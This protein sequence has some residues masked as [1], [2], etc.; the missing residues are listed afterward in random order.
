MDAKKGSVTI[1]QAAGR[2]GEG[3]E[4]QTYA[5]APKAEIAI[6]DGRGRRFSIKE[7]T[8]PDIAEGAI[9]TCALS[10]DKKQIQ[11]LVAEGP[12]FQGVIKGVDAA[13]KSVTIATPPGRGGDAEEKTLFVSVEATVVVDDGK[14]RR[15]SVKEAKLTDLPIGAHASV[16]MAP[17]GSFVM[18]LKAEGPSLIG[19]LKGVDAAKGTLVLAIPRGRDD[20]EEKTVTVA[21]G[22]RI[23]IDGVESTLGNLKVGDEG[24]IVQVRFGLDGSTAWT[25]FARRGGGRER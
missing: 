15:L 24:P 8:L 19:M 2:G 23:I 14:G 21:K 25:I 3:A 7:A 4:A 13:K 12:G 6:D 17:D 11:A 20:A 1:E 10:L 16:K 18:F 5:L 9:V 22:A